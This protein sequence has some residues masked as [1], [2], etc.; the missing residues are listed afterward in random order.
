MAVGAAISAF[1]VI[2]A[3]QSRRH[4]INHAE[5]RAA[6]GLPW[7]TSSDEPEPSSAQALKE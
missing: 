4:R 7:K 2:L 3:T 5:R 1:I 6:M